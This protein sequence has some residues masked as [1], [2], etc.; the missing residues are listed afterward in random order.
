MTDFGPYLRTLREG[1]GKSLR[2][3]T[4]ET[5]ISTGYLSLIEG[6]RRPPPGPRF[7]RRLAVC[8]GVSPVSLLLEAGHA[9]ELGTVPE[10][11]AEL[12][13]ENDAL[14]ARLAAIGELAAGREAAGQLAR[15]ET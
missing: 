4:R 14:R 11:V 13:R 3:V 9:G 8:Y 7:L 10:V 12:R 6:G 1:T 15:R 2:Q 5:G